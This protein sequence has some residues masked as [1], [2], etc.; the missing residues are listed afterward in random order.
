MR[1][2]RTTL[3]CAACG[4]VHHYPPSVARKRRYCSQA[5][6]TS[7]QR[8]PVPKR[9]RMT[10]YN[11]RVMLEHRAI[12]EAANGPIPPG[13]VVHH[14]NGDRL[15]NRLENLELMTRAEHT[16][17][18]S[19]DTHRTPRRPLG[20][21]S[22]WVDECRDCG[23]TDRDHAGYGLCFTCHRYRTVHCLLDLP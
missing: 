17:H 1:R 14:R 2:Q 20:R 15:D 4:A 16:R 11:G 18:H 9:Y 22:R 8:V 12:W 10:T 23:R 21:W 7:A 3:T 5:C 19:P 6:Y 13:L